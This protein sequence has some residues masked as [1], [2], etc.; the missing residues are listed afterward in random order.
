MA[1]YMHLDLCASL[2]IIYINTPRALL[3]KKLYQQRVE[4]C[5]KV[6]SCVR[7]LVGSKCMNYFF[8]PISIIQDLFYSICNFAI[9]KYGL[10]GRSHIGCFSCGTCTFKIDYV[11]SIRNNDVPDQSAELTMVKTGCVKS[12]A[13]LKNCPS[14]AAHPASFSIGY[15]FYNILTRD[16]LHCNNILSLPFKTRT[17]F[18]A[19][20][21]FVKTR[22]F[23][24]GLSVCICP[25]YLECTNCAPG[26]CLHYN[27][28]AAFAGDM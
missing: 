3:D 19:V 28:Y 21:Y 27:P 16:I 14:Y 1:P 23:I 2:C 17:Y 9:E 15:P 8:F 25:P 10:C 12:E 22:F 4:H 7:V 11:G 6:S 18:Y 20:C 26:F 5:L 24:H 13:L